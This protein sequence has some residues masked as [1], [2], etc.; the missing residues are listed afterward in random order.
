MHQQGLQF[1]MEEIQYAALAFMAL[2]FLAKVI[3]M[4]KR[5]SVLDKAHLKGDPAIGA[6]MSLGNIFMPL[7]MESTRIHWLLY[8]EFSVFHISVALAILSTFL[9]PLKVILPGD[10][11]SQAIAVSL[12][13][14]FTAGVRRFIRRLTVPEIRLISSKDDYF[15]I[16]IMDLFFLSG[17]WALTTGR[18]QALWIFFILTTFLLVYVPFS[19]ISHYIAYPFSRWYYGVNFGGRGVLNKIVKHSD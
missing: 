16:A 4:M 5:P 15:A 3:W 1:L 8:V 2:L 18:E 9:I 7:A 10:M 12:A 11:I 6:V 17:I 19:K 14:G 13:F